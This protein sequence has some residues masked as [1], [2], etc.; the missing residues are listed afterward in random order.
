MMNYSDGKHLLLKELMKLIRIKYFG[1]RLTEEQKSKFLAT[2]KARHNTKKVI[3]M[4]EEP[5]VKEKDG[6]DEDLHYIPI[7]PQ[8]FNEQVR[9]GLTEVSKLADVPVSKVQ[10]WEEKGYIEEA[11]HSK[12]TTERFRYGFETVQKANL[13]RQGLERGFNLRK[14][15]N[16]AEEVQELLEDTDEQPLGEAQYRKIQDKM[17]EKADEVFEELYEELKSEAKEDVPT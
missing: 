13:I 15:A 12:G 16:K 5:K 14:A 6:A 2:I 9:I 4:T 8:T 10:Y 1:G 11:E 7:D 17:L 3:T